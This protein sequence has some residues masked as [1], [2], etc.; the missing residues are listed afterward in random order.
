MQAQQGKRDMKQKDGQAGPGQPVLLGTKL[1]VP[2]PLACFIPRARL[3]DRLA[4]QSARLV[5]VV[6]AP[7]GFGKTALVAAWA[8]Q[9]ARPVAWLSLGEEDNHLP[10]FWGYVTA[11]LQT[12]C[13]PGLVTRAGPDRFTADL[14]EQSLAQLINELTAVSA[15]LTLVLDGYHLIHTPAIH[16]SLSSFLN[17][18]P[19]LLH[20]I[21]LTRADPPLGLARLMVQG[22]LH[23]IRA[24]DLLFTPAETAAFFHCALQ[25]DLPSGDLA[26]LTNRIEGW[27]AGLQLAALS[28]QGL[29]KTARESL[30]EAFGGAQRHV[31][32]YLLEEVLQRQPAEVQTFLLQTA[33][34]SHL[35]PPLCTAVTGHPEAGHMLAR[36]ADEALFIVP[37]DD[38]GQWYRYHHLFAEA[39]RSHLE[40]TNP[41]QAAVL[42]QRVAMWYAAQG[43]GCSAQAADLLLLE[44]LTERELEVLMLVA[45]GLPNK[46]IAQR[47]V[48]SVGTVKGHLNHLLSKL[49]AQNRTEAVAHAQRLGLIKT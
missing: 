8:R 21:L 36:L 11:A 22:R 31:L 17:H 27:P 16:Q 40:Q 23:E 10:C 7:A 49:N 35:T 28:L 32:H 13:P 37:L 41:A 47:L 38:N 1:G 5:T 29:P 42:R 4:G 43:L 30:I 46:K 18:Q 14:W 6:S 26:A 24:A 15:D 25:F 3:A 39:L 33:V 9:Q 44:P 2:P 34:L 45:E 12:A 19:A 20:V 48:I